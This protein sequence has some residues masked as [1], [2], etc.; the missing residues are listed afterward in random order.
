MADPITISA[1]FISQVNRR[2]SSNK[3]VRRNLP[4]WGRLHIDRQL[5]F[6]TVYRRPARRQDAGTER[7]IMG[8]PAY[9]MASAQKTV[10]PG[11]SQL[12]KSITQ[13][14]S[15]LFGCFLLVE[16]WSG[17]EDDP[18]PE[19]APIFPGPAFTIIAPHGNGLADT[20]ETL[21]NELA[22]IKI[23]QM[24]ATVNLINRSKPAPARLPALLSKPDAD[25]LNCMTIGII[26][27]P[28]YRRQAT[29]EMLPL[30]HRAM[31]RDV[32]LAI[33]RTFF[34]FVRNQT[35]YR[36]PHYQALGRRATVKAVWHIDK[37]LAQMNSSFDFLLQVTPINTREAWTN[38]KRKQF[39]QLPIFRYRPHP[40]DP[41][42]L[43]RQL[44]NIRLDRIEDPTIQHLFR[45]KQ[46]ELDIQISM[47]G[48]MNKPDFLYGSMQL[49]GKLDDQLVDTARG[50]LETIPAR[51]REQWGQKQVTA[52]AFAELARAEI[53]KY[54]QQF[55]DFKPQVLLRDDITGLMVSQGN[56]LVGSRVKLS[57][58]RVEALLEHE[59][60]THVLT[61]FNG[62]AQPFK[63]LSAGL[64]GYEELQEGLAVLAE[65]LV[66]GLSKPR[67]RLLAA[68]VVAAQYLID[69]ASFIDTFRL[70]KDSYHFKQQ[71]AFNIVTRIYRGGGYT[72]DA[73]YL[74]GLLGLLQYLRLEPLHEL[75]FIGKIAISHIPIIQELRRREVLHAPA[76]L[77]HF[78]NTL[79]ARL[80]LQSLSEGFSAIDLIERK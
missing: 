64:A 61:Y 17:L 77:P 26:V 75:F 1:Q 58:S 36:P 12:V 2:L 51:S 6:L 22:A 7:L 57:G 52:Q 28:I 25:R 14:M 15:E 79:E 74:R 43:K 8:Q 67:L 56:L 9:L 70:L 19:T 5:P 10:A 16:I 60:G 48:N 24:P 39:N 27:R 44:W 45:E 4:I 41:A 31:V 62:Q 34:I 80:R 32:N 30:V 29:G 78:L 18:Q 59:V 47:L 50:L 65:Y 72:K 20:I 35:S 33:Q 38:F 63:L 23:N 76:L 42:L 73:V 40:V 53:E 68:R 11:L 3:R 66:G 13:S 46:Q 71:F 54:R 21:E 37:Q 55:P 49:F 69:G